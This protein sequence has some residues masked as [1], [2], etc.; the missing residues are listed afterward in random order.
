[1][2]INIGMLAPQPC[3]HVSLVVVSLG[4]RSHFT[5]SRKSVQEGLITDIE[6]FRAI[7]HVARYDGILGRGQAGSS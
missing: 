4:S 1:M 3:A 5:C 7:Q 6:T 2:S